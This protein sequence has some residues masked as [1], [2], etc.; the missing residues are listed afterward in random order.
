MFGC[1]LIVFCCKCNNFQ[2]FNSTYK[3]Y[4]KAIKKYFSIFKELL[5]VSFLFNYRSFF[6]N[7]LDC[8]VYLKTQ[9]TIYHLKRALKLVCR[10]INQ[11]Y[12][13]L[14]VFF[15]HSTSFSF[16]FLFFLVLPLFIQIESFLWKK[17][18]KNICSLICFQHDEE[19]KRIAFFGSVYL[20]T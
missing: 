5:F 17:Y 1:C 2:Q 13:T 4:K 3:L 12:V 16:Q 7:S 11:C 10:A 9:I 15:L 6:K 14:T 8:D 20:L 18:K 19:G